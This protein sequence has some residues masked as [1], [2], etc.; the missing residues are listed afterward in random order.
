MEHWMDDVDVE[1]VL[2]G[3]PKEK[4]ELYVMNLVAQLLEQNFINM[5]STH[6]KLL[7][8]I[9]KIQDYIFSLAR[10]ELR[11]YGGGN[12]IEALRRTTPQISESEWE[13]F[14]SLGKKK[15]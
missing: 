10:A 7:S 12:P 13:T 3:W 8:D 4:A 6:R 1:T 11:E 14:R 2:A 5:D 9:E 15:L